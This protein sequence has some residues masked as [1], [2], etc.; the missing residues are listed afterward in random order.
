MQNLLLAVSLMISG[1]ALAQD[2]VDSHNLHMVPNDGELTDG[3]RTWNAETH[4]S[5]AFAGNVLFEYGKNPLSLY[6]Q[7]SS[8]TVSSEIIKSYS[9]LNLGLFYSPHERVALTA[10][11]PLFLS[12][13]GMVPRDGVGLGDVRLAVPVTLLFTNQASAGLSVVPFM[14]IPGV[15]GDSQMGLSGVAGGGLIA[16]TMH[17]DRVFGTANLGV[18]FTPSIDYYNMKGGERLL[19][20]LMG[21]VL[22][23]EEVALRGEVTFNP[24]LY[25]NDKPMGD[26]PMEAML[27]LRG[28]TEDRLSWT[29]GGAAALTD[30]VGAPVWRAFAGLDLAF[31]ARDTHDCRDSCIGSLAVFPEDHTSGELLGVDEAPIDLSQSEVNLPDGS[32]LIAGCDTTEPPGLVVVTE[33]ELLLLEPIYFDF[34]RSDIRFPESSDVLDALVAT[35]KSHPELT[36]IEVAGHTDQ[37]GSHSYNDTLSQARVDSV[38]EYLTS[39]GIEASRLRP[40]GYGERALLSECAS[41]DEVCH[42]KNRR[43][44]FTI[45]ERN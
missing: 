33:T 7:D 15:Y 35:L 27:S 13:D 41:N 29:F 12:V 28:Q 32:V 10:S 8:R 31:G 23:S 19:S 24:A 6:T 9:A 40:V 26:S 39:H 1:A 44:Q 25:K 30:S 2:S 42:Q 14:D 17:S 18:H 16:A 38:V 22:L 34:D 5:G 36:L 45:L 37:R 3:V 43:V 4:R 11:A 21:G 20:S